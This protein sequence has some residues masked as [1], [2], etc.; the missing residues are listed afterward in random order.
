M[1]QL[2]PIPYNNMQG[3]DKMTFEI[4]ADLT[5]LGSAFIINEYRMQNRIGNSK[6]TAMIAATSIGS[7]III[8]FISNIDFKKKKH[9][10]KRF[11]NFRII[12]T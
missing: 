3:S 11:K 6:Q 9:K 7:C 8:H 4:A 1:G 10:R 5:I 12:N 2:A